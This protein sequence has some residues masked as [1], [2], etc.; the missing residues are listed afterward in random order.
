MCSV[1]QFSLMARRIDTGKPTTS[2]SRSLTLS[3]RHLLSPQ[4]A[5]SW[6]PGLTQGA[7]SARP[8]AQTASFRTVRPQ[9]EACRP[10]RNPPAAW[11]GVARAR[12]PSWAIF[13]SA[14]QAG[15]GFGS[16]PPGR[17]RDRKAHSATPKANKVRLSVR[18]WAAD[19]GMSGCP[20]TSPTSPF[21]LI[22]FCQ[23]RCPRR[24]QAPAAAAH[25]CYR[26]RTPQR[27]SRYVAR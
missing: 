19:S 26:D 6:C 23:T 13:H 10:W 1:L 12:L 16:T 3:S 15:G 9:T 4:L 8:S 20:R 18:R 22:T 5:A 27:S 25:R 11:R 24:A 14:P 7:P 17:R 21:A 2:P